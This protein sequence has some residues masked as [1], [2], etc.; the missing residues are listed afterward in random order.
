VATKKDTTKTPKTKKKTEGSFFDDLLEKVG[1]EIP[2]AAKSDD[3]KNI[4]FLSTGSLMLNALV[5]GSM[6]GGIA[7]NKITALAGEEA[8]GKTFIALQCVQN[9]LDNNPKGEVFIF[10][11]EDDP[12]KLKGTLEQRGIDPNRVRVRRVN[13]I[14][15]F[16]H[17]AIQIIDK[18]LEYDEAKRPPM[19]FVLDSLGNLSTLKELHDT[20]KNALN[21]KGEDIRDMTRTSLIRGLFRVLT[22]KLGEAM[23]PLLITNHTYETMNPYGASKAMSGGGGLKYAASTI[24]FLG[25]KKLRDEEKDVIGSILTATL[26]KSRFTRYGLSAELL[27]THAAGLDRYW[28]LFDFGV[29]T[30]LLIKGTGI[31]D[32]ADKAGKKNGIKVNDYKFP[33]GQTASR[34]EIEA[35][36]AQY[37]E[38]PENFAAFEEQCAKSFLFGTGEAPP[39]LESDDDDTEFDIDAL[40]AE[41]DVPIEDDLVEAEADEALAEQKE[42][43]KKGKK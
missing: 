11:S 43:K 39:V 38:S 28:G 42:P 18:Y 10:D 3:T 12:S 20:A 30:G 7:A 19:F 41:D 9:F 4:K 2:V 37:F 17:K 29:E 27:L 22:I 34:K 24:V 8:T 16:R 25:K 15:D 14:Q 21:K 33:D 36:P 32:K 26:D 40:D 13:T 23:V 1:L 6:N 31:P 35:N 5:S